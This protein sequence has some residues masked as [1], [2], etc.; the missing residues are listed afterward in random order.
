M[1][2][3]SAD[4][5]MCCCAFQVG[6]AQNP[7]STCQSM[8]IVFCRRF[9]PGP[10]YTG[11]RIS[12][13]INLVGVLYVLFITAVFIMPT[14]YPV[15]STTLNWCVA[16]HIHQ[17]IANLCFEMCQGFPDWN[18][19]LQHVRGCVMMHLIV[20]NPGGRQGHSRTAVAMV[21]QRDSMNRCKQGPCS[22]MLRHTPFFALAGHLWQWA[23]CWCGPLGTGTCP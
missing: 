1:V 2:Q 22:A 20:V 5:C 11:H 15:T 19:T 14:A 9:R 3:M 6:A 7:L 13:V 12:F 8:R 4:A 21:R 17:T 23:L 18:H 16:A 10:I